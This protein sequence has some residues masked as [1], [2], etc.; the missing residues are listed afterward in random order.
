MFGGI[1]FQEMLVIGVVAVLLFGRKLPEVARNAGSAYREL[2]KQIGDL[3]S[4][5]TAI[6]VEP[7]SSRVRAVDYDDDTDDVN[8]AP[9][10][11]RFEPPTE[12]ED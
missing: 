4:S 11:P 12:D 9:S 5:F 10:A 3:Q 7:S 8:D 6:D 1:G 2:R